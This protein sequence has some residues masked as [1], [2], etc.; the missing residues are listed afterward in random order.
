MTMMMMM[1]MMTMM[2]L[3]MVANY[4]D[5]LMVEW[6]DEEAIFLIMMIMMM[7]QVDAI[8]A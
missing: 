2:K 5:E 3:M 8:G 1:T 6:K 7:I 4:N